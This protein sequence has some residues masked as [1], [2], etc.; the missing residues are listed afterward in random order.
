MPSSF[1]AYAADGDGDGRRDIWA[2]VP[3][4][5]ASIANF[6]KEHGWRPGEAVAVRTQVTGQD[7][8]KLLDGTVKPAYLPKEL[9]AAGVA[10]PEDIPADRLCTL[11]ELQSA[12][13]PNEYWIGFENFYVVTRYNR[14]TFYASAVLELGEAIRKERG[15]VRVAAVRALTMTR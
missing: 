5:L 12:G 1:L 15:A 7:Y 10:V 14:S 11:L 4:V 9:A 3:D 13:L 2:S 6:L 8:R